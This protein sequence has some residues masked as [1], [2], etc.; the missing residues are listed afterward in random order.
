VYD[1]NPQQQI[2]AMWVWLSEGDKAG[3]PDGVLHDPIELIPTD[4]PIIYRNFL[5]GLTPRGIAV[6]YPELAHL[7]WDANDMCLKLIWHGRFI[8]ASLHWVGRGPGNQRP[9]GDHVM[10]LESTMPIAALGSLMESWPSESPRERGATFRG[11]KLDESG[12]PA[13]HY[14]IGDIDVT[15]FPM[16]V[17]SEAEPDAGFERVIT[18]TAPQPVENLYF[19]AATG[20]IARQDDGSY[21]VDDAMRIAI[22][23]GGEPIVREI[24]GRQELLV[25]LSLE[26]GSCEVRQVIKW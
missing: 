17:A 2:L 14:T 18:V 1:G 12:R 19:R 20:R 26:G 13:F 3:I 10:R 4:R 25:P 15:D 16:P 8:D 9:L 7:A 24:D 11:Y 6:G 21:L 23:Q 22:T 5:D